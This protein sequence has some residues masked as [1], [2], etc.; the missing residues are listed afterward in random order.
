MKARES[1]IPASE[2]LKLAWAGARIADL[3]DAR[4]KPAQAA[5]WRKRLE[6][7]NKPSQQ[8]MRR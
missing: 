4:G 7:K 1:K 2:K 5:E 8:E 6:A 3:H